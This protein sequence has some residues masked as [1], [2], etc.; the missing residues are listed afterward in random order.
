M[1]ARDPPSLLRAGRVLGQQLPGGVLHVTA[2]PGLWRS[3]PAPTAQPSTA[4]AADSRWFPLRCS[5]QGEP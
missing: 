4:R 3:A 5:G 1:L 2:V